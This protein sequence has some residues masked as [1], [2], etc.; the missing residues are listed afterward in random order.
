MAVA[1]VAGRRAPDGEAQKRLL[2][3]V[4]TRLGGR[5]PLHGDLQGPELVLRQAAALGELL[6]TELQEVLVEHM[7][8]HHRARKQGT[9]AEQPAGPQQRER[10]PRQRHEFVVVRDAAALA[11]LVVALG[12]RHEEVHDRPQHPVGQRLEPP[13]GA[14][15]LRRRELLE[16]GVALHPKP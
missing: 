2:Q 13:R 4:A 5:H 14:Q 1:A 6:K 7:V 10:V 11:E 3:G 15:A 8:E 16:E 12:D 9:V